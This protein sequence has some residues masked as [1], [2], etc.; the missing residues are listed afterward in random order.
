MRAAKNQNIPAACVQ[1]LYWAM[2]AAFFGFFTAFLLENGYSDVQVGW[3]STIIYLV[4]TLLGSLTGYITDMLIPA[5]KLLI[6]S[7]LFSIPF[8]ILVPL[9]VG[10]FPLVLGCIIIVSVLQIL[11]CGVV[12]AWIMRIREKHTELSY[13][14][15]R[16]AGS[17]VYAIAAYGVGLLIARFGYAYAFGANIVF[18]LATVVAMLFLENVP[19][20]GR[21]ETDEKPLSF[22]KALSG[23]ARC[24]EYVIY[25]AAMILYFYGMRLTL[26]FQPNLI[27][28]V[29]GT[30]ADVGA[31]CA[32]AAVFEIPFVLMMTR[33]DKFAKPEMCFFSLLIGAC[34]GL[35]MLLFPTVGAYLGAQVFQAVSYGFQISFSL[36]YIQRVTP[37]HLYATA[38]MV[39]TTANMGISCMLAA[40]TG[41]Y[42]FEVSDTLLLSASSV[43]MV[44]AAAVFALTFVKR[45]SAQ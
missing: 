26:V 39:Y 8:V 37:P 41:G 43:T 3:I 25:V 10:S 18:L 11:M 29:G 32:I 9:T 44:L 24:R 14:L 7:F 30:S 27:F 22:W 5:K 12:D 35:M 40:L 13:P 45:R 34:K 6:L 1:A 31:A 16:S 15:T 2:I 4:S 28:A 17:L 33:A 42:M 19:I 36:Y 21:R 20:Q 23:L 38:I